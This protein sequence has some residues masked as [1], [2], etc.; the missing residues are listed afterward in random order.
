M[1]S[2]ADS[3]EVTRASTARV[4]GVL[5]LLQPLL[6]LRPAGLLTDVDGTISRITAH[7]NDATV[8]RD[9][10]R[11]L[12]R[13]SK[14]LDVVAVITGRAIERAQQMVNV[15]GLVYIGNHGLEWLVDGA[16]QY[17]PEAARARP[18][19][20]AA[21]AAIHTAAP[22]PGLVVE[23]K[24]VS[25]A[26]HYRQ[27]ADPLDAERRI[28]AALRPFVAPGGGSPALRLIKGGL[29]VN[30][31]PALAVDKGAAVRKLVEQ[32]SLRA[33]AFFGDDVTDLD[34]IRALHALRAAGMAQTLAVGVGSAEGPPAIR[35]EADVMLEGV[36]EVE[37][38]LAALARRPNGYNPAH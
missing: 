2:E 17:H 32:Y 36:A 11:D 18:T 35:A 37:R 26:V 34:A 22:E 38:V 19:L 25:I 12:G 3:V 7:T 31:L 1:S 20:D 30:L 21:L 9:T 4:R 27:T 13:L 14:Q 33:V 6:A 5:R 8:E 29:V 15:T 24:H 10:R 23:D 28:L 16:V